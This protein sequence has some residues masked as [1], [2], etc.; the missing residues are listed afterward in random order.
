ML[1]CMIT[2]QT[3]IAPTPEP[4]LRTT[5]RRI[6]VADDHPL[7]RDALARTLR[8]T[9]RYDV[10]AEPGDGI[11]ALGAIQITRPDAALVDVRMPELDGLALI[12]RLREHG[13]A[14]PVVLLSAFTDARVVAHAMRAG[15]AGYLAKDL[16][17][18]ALVVALDRALAGERPVC[19]STAP[20]AERPPLP[21]LTGREIEMLSLLHNGWT[22]EEL[23]TVADAQPDTVR[24]HLDRARGKLGAATI[25]EAV[26]AAA[27]R[28]L[29][30]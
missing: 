9:G 8:R 22:V 5:R 15:A 12:A 28:D 20:D 18:E 30:R 16:D 29:L 1:A 13:D 3:L 4:V 24:G 23:A 10:I 27:A 2:S 6:V 7:F 26:A 21:A 25:D 11:A 14:T 17:R 19:L